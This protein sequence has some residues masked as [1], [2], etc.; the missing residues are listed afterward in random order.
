MVEKLVTV[1]SFS[2]QESMMHSAIDRILTV[3]RNTKMTLI[4]T[5]GP[6]FVVLFIIKYTIK[7]AVLYYL[8]QKKK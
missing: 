6:F 3:H 2:Q 4:I 1:N 7:A 5:S 8:Y